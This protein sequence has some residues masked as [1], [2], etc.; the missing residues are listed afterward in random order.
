M[1][2][3]IKG[4][5]KGNTLGNL[6]K[7]RKLPPLT[8][9]HKNKLRDANIRNGNKPPSPKGIIRSPETRE[10]MRLGQLGNSHALGAVRS[11]ET[12]KKISESLKGEKHFN[13]K[14]GRSS[15]IEKLRHNFE[16][17]LWREAVFKRDN[18]TCIWCGFHGYVQADH[19]KPFCDYPE[20]RFAI[21]NGRT[22]C[23]PCH[24]KTSTY[25]G[26]KNKGV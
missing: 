20:L 14:G 21:D 11:L 26:H 19:I 22:L 6:N 24:K 17:K 7:G 8:I 2:K 15:E 1:P 10:K 18:W 23:V 5:V 4:F 12:R 25:G 16:Y 3:G 9:E 13:W